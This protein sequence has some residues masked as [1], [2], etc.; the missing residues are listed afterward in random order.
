[1]FKKSTFPLET[2]FSRENF[3]QQNSRFPN[4]TLFSHFANITNFPFVGTW[5]NP[6]S[7]CAGTY[8][9]GCICISLLCTETLYLFDYTHIILHDFCKKKEK[10]VAVVVVR[11]GQYISRFIL[12][13][14]KEGSFRTQGQCTIIIMYKYSRQ[15]ITLIIL[16]S[17]Q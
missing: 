13:A 9:H 3:A 16:S 5:Q 12:P 15:L 2:F 1:M 7:F 10:V 6:F 11:P 4:F 8:I 17:R 14:K